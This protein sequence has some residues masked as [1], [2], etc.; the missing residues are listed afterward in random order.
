MF[1]QGSLKELDDYKN[2]LSEVF[3]YITDFNASKRTQQAQSILNIDVSEYEKAVA[4][5]EDLLKKDS[6]FTESAAKKQAISEA[7]KDASDSLKNYAAANDLTSESVGRFKQQQTVAIETMQKTSLASKA[8]SVGVGLLSA[9]LSSIVTLAVVSTI[10]ALITKIDEL[11]HQ[12]E[13]WLEKTQELKEKH[14]ELESEIASLTSELDNLNKQIDELEDKDHL[15]LTE[16]S[17]LENL[18]NQR[19]ELYPHWFIS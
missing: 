18:R 13:I 15:T 2:K 19:L 12:E 1:N 10:Q 3:Q 4:I 6:A 5:Y 16:Q 8:A 11:L 17:D 7:F 9:A 14:E